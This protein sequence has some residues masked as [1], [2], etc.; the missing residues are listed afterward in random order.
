M[1]WKQLRIM[2][3]GETFL[4]I[5]F[6]GKVKVVSK[7]ATGSL[8]AS[9]LVSLT[10]DRGVASHK[11]KGPRSGAKDT[12]QMLIL[13]V[14]DGNLRACFHRHDLPTQTFALSPAN[15]AKSWILTCKVVNLLKTLLP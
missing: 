4:V 14:L 8:V 13:H 11:D 3:K 6:T 12:E 1:D 9:S 7:L 2:R 10:F 15:N 5:K